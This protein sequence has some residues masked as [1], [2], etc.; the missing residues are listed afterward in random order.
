MRLCQF[1]VAND[2]Q[3][4]TRLLVGRRLRLSGVLSQIDLFFR[5]GRLCGIAGRNTPLELCGQS[6]SAPSAMRPDL[7]RI[8][9]SPNVRSLVSGYRMT[10]L[11][12][13]NTS[14]VTVGFLMDSYQTEVAPDQRQGCKNSPEKCLQCFRQ[15]CVPTVIQTLTVFPFRFQSP[16]DMNLGCKI[17][18]KM[19]LPK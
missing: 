15:C 1:R 14:N 4:L 3:L 18:P 5:N 9:I 17:P 12:Q 6:A 2:A 8:S 10:V 16:G 19:I 13:Y 7:T 11:R